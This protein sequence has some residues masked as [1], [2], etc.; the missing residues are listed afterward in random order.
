MVTVLPLIGALGAGCGNPDATLVPEMES[1]G[2]S[3]I[4]QPSM[5]HG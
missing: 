2:L 4:T 5:L 3:C 1:T